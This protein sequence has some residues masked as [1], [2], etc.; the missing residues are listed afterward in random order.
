MYHKLFKN[1]CLLDAFELV[2][3]NRNKYNNLTTPFGQIDLNI[4]YISQRAQE[5][6]QKIDEIVDNLPHR[7]YLEIF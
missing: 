7:E 1:I 5:L 6:R 2:I 3:N 4:D